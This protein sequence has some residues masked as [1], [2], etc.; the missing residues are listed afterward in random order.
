[1]DVF[2]CGRVSGFKHTPMNPSNWHQCYKSLKNAKIR[3]KLT[4]N[5]PKSTFFYFL[6]YR[7]F[8]SFT[9]QS[10]PT[11]LLDKG[12]HRDVAEE[13]LL[14]SESSSDS[15]ESQNSKLSNVIL[16]TETVI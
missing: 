2:W 7:N 10:L 12:K 8:N 15:D 11:K 1:M 3:P 13:D 6:V 5:S 4:G 16:H 9:L 14:K